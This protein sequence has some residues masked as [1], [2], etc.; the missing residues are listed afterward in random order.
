MKQTENKYVEITPEEMMELILK[1]ERDDN[2]T[3]ELIITDETISIEISD[4]LVVEVQPNVEHEWLLSSKDVAEGYGLSES[5]LRNTK[6]RYSDELLEG[7]HWVLS[8]NGT[9]LGGRPSTYWTKEGVVM[10]GFFIKTPTAKEFRR[11]ASNFIV[12]KSK[13]PKA[14][15]I[16]MTYIEA[17]QAHLESVKQLEE[18]NKLIALQAPKVKIYDDL[19]SKESLM[20][21]MDGCRKL[22]ANPKLLLNILKEKGYLFNN[23]KGELRPRPKALDKGWFVMREVPNYKDPEDKTREYM[24][25]TLKG[26][27]EIKPIADEAIAK[28]LIKPLGTKYIKV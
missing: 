2:M 15:S 1:G 16:P 21:P 27:T 14:P 10:L 9:K 17:L 8:Q 6:T 25:M 28:G 18:A 20:Y 19:M 22:T 7:T 26:V 3:K 4:E 12:E 5:G 24:F 23:N 13:E 11:W